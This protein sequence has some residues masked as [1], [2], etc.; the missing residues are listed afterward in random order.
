MELTRRSI[1]LSNFGRLSRSVQRLYLPIIVTWL[2]V[3][4]L[5]VMLVPTFFD[6]VS[7]DISESESLSPTDSD[8][9]AAQKI[10]DAQ[11]P[12]TVNASTHNMILVI[13]SSDV[14]SDDLRRSV[15]ALN[16]TI[17]G[18][19]SIAN[20]T[21]VTSIYSA[22]RDIL[23]PTLSALKDQ[24][25]NLDDAI[26][27]INSQLYVIQSNLSSIH[28]LMFELEGGVN[29]TAQLV[30]GIPMTF[31][32]VW[33][34]IASQG[35]MDPYL[36]NREANRTVFEATQAFGGDPLSLGYYSTFFQMWNDS[37]MDPSI[38]DPLERTQ[39]AVDHSVQIF[40]QNAPVDNDTKHLLLSVATGLDLQKWSRSDAIKNLTLNIV[41]QQ[42]SGTTN[43][44]G[45]APSKDLLTKIYN[46]PRSSSEDAFSSLTIDL[47]TEQLAAQDPELVASI[48]NGTLGV[49]T[50][51][52]IISV[53][54]LGES[55]PVEASWGLASQLLARSSA[56]SLA[57]SPIFTVNEHILDSTLQGLIS[58]NNLENVVDN[59]IANHSSNE[60]PLILTKR[61]S[62][63]FVSAD[64]QTMVVILGFKSAPDTSTISAVRNSLE[65][66][67]LMKSATVYVTGDAVF[68]ED[69]TQVFESA[70]LLTVIAGVGVSVLIAVV[71]FRSPIAAI[72]PLLISGISIAISYAAIYL[73]VVVIGKSMISFL[74]PI[75][76]TLLLLGLGVDYS[77]ILL[78][79]MREE[80][81]QGSSKEAS[82]ETSTRWGGQ[83]VTTAG[84]AVIISY[85]VMAIA[86][87]PLFSDIGV[88]I[89][90]GVM[91]LLTVAITL[92]PALET[93]LG[94]K[95]FWPG[96][97]IGDKS[98]AGRRPI[99]LRT[100]EG[101]LRW[102]VPVAVGIGILALGAL[103]VSQT[104]PTGMDFSKL[105]PSF[106]SNQGIT[107]ISENMNSGAISP[108]HV[109]VALPGSIVYGSSE[110]NRTQLDIVERMTVAISDTQGVSSVISTTWPFGEPFDPNLLQTLPEAVRSQYLTQMMRT[111]GNDNST[112]LITV[113][114]ESGPFESKSTSSL[115]AIQSAVK[116]LDLPAEIR[117]NYGGVVQSLYDSQRLLN[118][119]FPQV[120]V[121]LVV[122]IYFLLFIQL[123]SAFTP[124]RLIYTIL[125][126]VTVALAVTYLLFYHLLTLPILNFVPLF[127]VVTMLGVGID[128]DIFLVTRIR[129]EVLRGK[130]DNEAI[131][132]AVTKVGVTIL[133]LGLIL[134][135]V[136]LSLLFTGIPILEE[137]GFAVSTAV[138]FDTFII[139]LFAVPALMGLAQRLNWWPTKPK[140]GENAVS[141]ST[142]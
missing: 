77:M 57:E 106:S 56:A 101:T 8:A 14:L 113:G 103:Y 73:V 105:L 72:L 15:L 122:A 49:S 32:H 80:R 3:V 27:M 64:N 2:I 74:T 66:S 125:V 13:Q 88:A 34:T 71:L 138:L 109:V 114:F 124:L 78:R 62:E 137:I 121:M 112:V 28:S 127:V 58:V 111:I 45:L 41:E 82:V 123:R 4:V 19:V 135:S 61:V 89:A 117:V 18:D 96:L 21:G 24:T 48:S 35:P 134:A 129:E 59:I 98:R 50:R 99:L 63:N 100:S 65:T 84:F 94:D 47:F 20:F 60:S 75:L 36:L 7:Y 86:Q 40:T 52:F 11:F 131:K 115:L 95:L 90:I 54:A 132:T 6:S 26:R 118:N 140:R 25:T 23:L 55:P 141:Q 70:H 107:E 85:I 43:A 97:K 51:E 29:Q 76:V 9:L 110:F 119:V 108:T 68:S 5:S 139:I 69:M 22:E 126:S 128:Y 10:L 12:S 37:F 44:T 33:T 1:G 39:L 17:G 102:K 46:I 81:S 83:A 30:F 91:I 104:T 87:V 53:Q 16:R 130:S 136:F 42:M 79:R 67:N 38:K 92:V 142:K 120:I 93:L 31:T 133:G 116:E